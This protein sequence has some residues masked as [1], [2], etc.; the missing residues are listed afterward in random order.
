MRSEVMDTAS[1]VYDTVIMTD[2]TI[3]KVDRLKTEY[4]NPFDV[5]MHVEAY[6]NTTTMI[7]ID[8][9]TADFWSVGANAKIKRKC[10][11]LVMERN[12]VCAHMMLVWKET[13]TYVIEKLDE[14]CT[15]MEAWVSSIGW[16][17]HLGDSPTPG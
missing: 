9:P 4:G 7:C 10:G 8:H 6:F 17:G 13:Q 1:N 3:Q 16:E 2:G 12:F 5:L 11:P 14:G 15:L